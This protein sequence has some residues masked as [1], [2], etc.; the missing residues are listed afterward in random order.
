M[1]AFDVVCTIG[2]SVKPDYSLLGFLRCGGTI[3]CRLSTDRHCHSPLEQGGLEVS[4]ELIFVVD[5]L[6]LLTK[7][8]KIISTHTH[9][10]TLTV[11]I[12]AKVFYQ[13]PHNLET[14]TMAI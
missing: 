11:V 10:H 7:L 4:C 5:D 12:F 3:I 13:D 8:K 2:R 1:H 6:K 9:I 14:K